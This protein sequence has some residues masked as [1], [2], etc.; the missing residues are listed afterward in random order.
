MLF[1]TSKLPAGLIPSFLKAWRLVWSSAP[2]WSLCWIILLVLQGLLPVAIVYLTRDIV[3]GLVGILG[4]GGGWTTV[5]P[6]LGPL[7]LMAGVMLLMLLLKAALGLLRTVQAQLVR[8]RISVLVQEKSTALDVSF[9]ELSAYYDKLYRAQND[10][11]HR[12]VE[13]LESLGGLFQ[14]SL[15]LVAMGLVLVPYGFWVPLALLISTLPALFVVLAHR[16]RYHRWCLENTEDE[17]RSWYYNWLLTSRE[18]AAEV[19]MFGLARYFKSAFITLRKRLRNETVRLHRAQAL[20][21]LGASLFALL[22]TAAAMGWMLWRAVAGVVT[23]GDLALF[24]QAF[25]QGQRLMR[26]VLEEFGKMYGNSLFL[27]DFF[28]FLALEPRIG[29]PEHPVPPPR[30]INRG[31]RFADLAFR[32]PGAGKDVFRDFNLT[33]EA[34]TI[35]AIVGANGAGKSTLVKLLCRLYDPCSGTISFDDTDIRSCSVHE[36]RKM[37]TVLFQE[38]VRYETTVRENICLGDISIPCTDRAVREAARAS[39]ADKFVAACAGGYET[40]LGRWFS[41]GIDLSGGEWQRLALARAFLR[42]TPVIVLDEPTSGMDSWSELD[43]L[44]RFRRLARGRTVL[45]VAHRFTTAMQA[46]IIH[47]LEDGAVVESGSHGE[48]VRMGGRYAASWNEQLRGN[49]ARDD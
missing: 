37:V 10:A 41:G 32:Y 21:E 5:Q 49:S 20:G 14:N 43:W 26:S 9:Y 2:G 44:A 31:I 7:G 24:Y 11:A 47:V 4:T 38:P 35:T 28:E 16:I 48:L 46:D 27:V 33:L 40:V 15:T 42:N 18:S 23:M 19:R 8:D 6:L 36:I 30:T 22:V 29:D 12:P 13:L 1:S 34:G 3:D 45:L 39:G 17:R 25:S